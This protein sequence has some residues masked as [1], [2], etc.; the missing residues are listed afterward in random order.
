MR[1]LVNSAQKKFIEIN[2]E[3]LWPMVGNH[4]KKI[5]KKDLSQLDIPWPIKD[6]KN[7]KSKKEKA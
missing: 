5:E 7:K 4:I 2:R 6:L 3:I 1:L